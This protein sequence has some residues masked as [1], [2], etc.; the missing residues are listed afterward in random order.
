MISA[1]TIEDAA[2]RAAKLISEGFLSHVEL[3]SKYAI[4]RSSRRETQLLQDFLNSCNRSDAKIYLQSDFD[5]LLARRQ[6][7]MMSFFMALYLNP[8]KIRQKIEGTEGA[9]PKST[10]KP[11]SGGT[12]GTEKSNVHSDQESTD[13]THADSKLASHST[14]APQ[15][16]NNQDVET[17][18]VGNSAQD[19]ALAAILGSSSSTGASTRDHSVD[20][21]DD[22]M[23]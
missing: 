3:D 6:S 19:N 2:Q 16:S 15:T 14:D 18:G 23:L 4:R 20:L 1:T 8:D 5:G 22:E 7:L 9:K 21:G 11:T 12:G 10:S 13:Y 17:S